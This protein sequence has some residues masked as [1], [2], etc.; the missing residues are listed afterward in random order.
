MERTDINIADFIESFYQTEGLEAKLAV[1]SDFF[2]QLGI[3]RSFFIG[4]SDYCKT[5][6]LPLLGV[7]IP[8]VSDFEKDMVLTEPDGISGGFQ[9][10][11]FKDFACL[12]IE[13]KKKRYGYLFFQPYY[14]NHDDTLRVVKE[15][16]ICAVRNSEIKEDYNLKLRQLE[17]IRRLSER[18]SSTY[19]LKELLNM[20]T[21]EVSHLL[22]VKGTVIRLVTEDRSYLE[23]MS[24]YGL[25]DVH[26]RRH[27]IKKGDG[28]SGEVWEKGVSKLVLPDTDESVHLL[29]SK[30]N[31]SSL[32][33]VP[34]K[35]EMEVI[36]TMSV[37]EKLGEQ[38]FREEDRNF[39]E[40]L[41]SL[42]APVIAYTATIEREKALLI[43]QEKHLKNLT[44]ITEINR[45]LM[46]PRKLDNLLFILLTTLTFGEE[47]GFNRAV[48]F[49]YNAKTGT[50][51]GMMGIGCETIEEAY[52]V[53]QQLPKD[54]T[55][56]QWV[57]KIKNLEV[58][59]DT[60]FNQ[61]VKGLRF[62]LDEVPSLAQAYN[63]RK[64]Y[65][66]RDPGDTL[67]QI[68]GVN[69]YAIIPLCGREGVLGMLYVDNKFTY[70]QK[71][72]D[73]DYT[74]LLETF[75]SQASIAIENAKLFNEL[76]ET[77]EMLASARQ[78]LLMKEKLAVVGEML[79][80]LAHELRNPL[81]S[82]G[83]FA[84]L[85]EKRSE[86][87]Q[88]AELAN[89]IVLQAERVN[90]LFNDFLYLTKSN[91]FRQGTCDIVKVV[92]ES[93]NNLSFLFTERIK[94]KLDMQDNMP[95]V[96]IED[97]VLGVVIDNLLKNAAQAMKNGGEIKIKGYR[98]KDHVVIIVEDDGPGI[99]R[100]ALPYIFDP[101]YTTKFNGIG[102]GLSV[103]YKI[104]KQ[105][106]GLIYAENVGEKGGARFVIK[107]PCEC[108]L[109]TGENKVAEGNL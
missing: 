10:L 79:A 80:T 34:L 59:G 100:D 5:R 22:N 75:A 67:A 17:I 58:L 61:K 102:V 94:I 72:I 46:E 66:E 109:D 44:L 108:P 78:E 85:I 56:V 20:I 29:K 90:R 2:R 43:K 9:P 36:G 101:F 30:L 64:V 25:E 87:K 70:S 95:C 84:K 38:I 97:T 54:V 81:V 15:V 39:L 45:V 74:K 105:H 1:L 42:I 31:V 19:S 23:V 86:D 92:N 32:I 6:M 62:F 93:I 18:I 71:K 51:Q 12:K 52:Q 57:E 69:E 16:V 77:N 40:A 21:E 89:K 68:F 14:K 27:G 53:W 47:I 98:E 106:N 33:C 49:M 65:V 104:I 7:D 24:E 63:T 11:L 91:T 28:V 8:F 60:T 73:E 41:G 99:S 48:L 76:R 26:I 37:Y 96:P 13:D 35:F 83:G 55:A 50:L 4:I 88:I 3:E 82:M 103:T 107:L